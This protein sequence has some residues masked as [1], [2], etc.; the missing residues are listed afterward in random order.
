M[1]WPIMGEAAAIVAFGSV[2]V[3]FLIVGIATLDHP[4]VAAGRSWVRRLI[5]SDLFLLALGIPVAIALG[6]AV[7]QLILGADVSSAEPATKGLGTVAA[8]AAPTL[9]PAAAVATTEYVVRSGDTLKSIASRFL[10]SDAE[11]VRIY[12]ANRAAIADPDQLM[13]GTRISIPAD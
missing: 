13:V 4:A 8:S 9:P 1:G 12:E 6:L 2:A 11:W 10:G 5:G 3:S 7:S